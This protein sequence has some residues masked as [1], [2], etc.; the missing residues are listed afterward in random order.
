V[1]KK[2]H[3]KTPYFCDPSILGRVGSGWRCKKGTRV[4]IMDLQALADQVDSV[5]IVGF[6]DLQ[7]FSDWSE[8]QQ[9][10]EMLEFAI[11]LFH[12]TGRAIENAGGKQIKAI[13]DM[14]LFVFSADDPDRAVNALRHMKRDCDLWLTEY[15]Y[16]GTMAI[17]VQLGPI[18]CGM[19]GAAGR[20]QFDL[21]GLAVNRAA[22]MRG[23]GIVL[24]PGLA[25]KF[26]EG[27]HFKLR[28]IGNDGFQ[29]LD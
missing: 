17:R 12:R 16:P 24:G 21:Y 10:R 7:G 19:V 11:A 28:K 20:E 25:E 2:F 1:D 18:S 5:A 22:M 8:T 6:F 13:G 9:P 23:G 15:G 14:G 26:V 4:S 27:S 29:V 3:E